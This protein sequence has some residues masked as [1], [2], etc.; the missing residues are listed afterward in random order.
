VTIA[1]RLS[2][3]QDSDVLFVIGDGRLLEQGSHAD[4]MTAQGAYYALVQRGAE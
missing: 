1:H 3:I 2:T 4:L